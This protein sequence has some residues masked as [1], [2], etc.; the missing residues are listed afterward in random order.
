MKKNV[1]DINSKRKPILEADENEEIIKIT[2]QYKGNTY[3]GNFFGE[4]HYQFYAYSLM[5]SVENNTLKDLL[6]DFI[7]DNTAELEVPYS[8]KIEGEKVY[9]YVYDLHGN[10]WD[11]INDFNPE[12]FE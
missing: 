2:I 5:K 9:E 6:K 11:C 1:I 4:I 7:I 8:Y 12:L 3:I 10:L